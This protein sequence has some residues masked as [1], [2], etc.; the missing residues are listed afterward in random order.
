ME[1]SRVVNNLVDRLSV[2]EVAKEEEKRQL[3]AARAAKGDQGG[4]RAVAG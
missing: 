2:E 3:E 4:A 1:G